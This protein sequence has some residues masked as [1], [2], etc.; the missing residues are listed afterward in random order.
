M[1][2]FAVDFKVLCNLWIVIQMSLISRFN[3]E[4]C[5]FFMTA[6]CLLATLLL[7][8]NIDE[9]TLKRRFF[10]M[11]FSFLHRKRR[12]RWLN[13]VVNRIFEF[14]YFFMSEAACSPYLYLIFVKKLFPLSLL[15]LP[16]TCIIKIRTCIDP[17][18]II[19]LKHC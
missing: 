8:N 14:E 3:A 11:I 13:F 12:I 18:V 17:L 19:I 6:V 16:I 15:S 1:I 10:G 9:N 7:S 4:S 5:N 2:I